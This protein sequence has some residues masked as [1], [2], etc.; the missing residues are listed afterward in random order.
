MT[1]YKLLNVID[2][3]GTII[4]NEDI[5]ENGGV[6]EFR[7]P[8]GCDLEHDWTERELRY[9]LWRKVR[10]IEIENGVFYIEV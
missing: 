7:K 4:D 6:Y 2:G 1:V 8:F 5:L 10:Y 3:S 9:I